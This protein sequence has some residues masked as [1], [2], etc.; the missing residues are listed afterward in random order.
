MIKENGEMSEETLRELGVLEEPKK[1]EVTWSVDEPIGNHDQA[2]IATAALKRL[3]RAL[4]QHHSDEVE[5]TSRKV[6]ERLEA[7]MKREIGSSL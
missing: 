1:N 2:R 6:A 4:K 3:R 7:W 5:V